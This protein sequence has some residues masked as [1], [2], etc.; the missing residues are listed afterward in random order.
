[1]KHLDSV[2]CASNGHHGGT[3]SLYSLCGWLGRL[4]RSSIAS[5]PGISLAA[6]FKHPCRLYDGSYIPRVL[7]YSESFQPYFPQVKHHICFALG[8]YG[9]MQPHAEL[10][11]CKSPEIERWVREQLPDMTTVI[12][13]PSIDRAIFDYDGRP[14]RDV[15]CY[16]TRRNKHPET[17]QL[18]RERYGDKV[19]EIVGQP[20]AE[21]A[22]SLRQAKVFVWRGNDLEGSPRPPKEALVAG[23]VVVGL[24]SDLHARYDTDFGLKCS[25]V[26]ELLDMAGQGLR[27]PIPT[28]QERAVVRDTA[29]EM[30]DWL[31]LMERFLEEGPSGARP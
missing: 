25:S 27:M 18:L 26:D 20:E 23:C 7:V 30:R 31:A 17:S 28:P 12:I 3:K 16:M 13:R 4:G 8:K 21:V 19:L 15:I 11:V 29:Q 2:V 22:E 24:A 10:T 5:R 6:W 1:M 14:K 9:K